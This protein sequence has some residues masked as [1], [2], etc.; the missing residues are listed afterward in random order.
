MADIG[1][2]EVESKSTIACARAK[3]ISDAYILS[4]IL[5]LSLTLLGAFLLDGERDNFVHVEPLHNLVE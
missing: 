3:S 5:S 1:T 4:D 2:S